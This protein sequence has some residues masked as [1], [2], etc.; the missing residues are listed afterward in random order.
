MQNPQKEINGVIISSSNARRL[1]RELRVLTEMYDC[2]RV[3]QY[4]S[5]NVI[6]DPSKYKQEITKMKEYKEEIKKKEA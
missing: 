4:S 2:L 3:K 6:E 5:S 1:E